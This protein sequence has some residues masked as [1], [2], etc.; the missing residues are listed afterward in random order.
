MAYASTPRRRSFDPIRKKLAQN[1]DL[2]AGPSSVHDSTNYPG[3]R[4]IVGGDETLTIQLHNIEFDG[5]SLDF[6]R[7]AYTLAIYYPSALATNYYANEE[8]I[9]DED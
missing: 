6:P 9:D 1:T 5:A 2:F 4:K 8:S 7:R 3:D